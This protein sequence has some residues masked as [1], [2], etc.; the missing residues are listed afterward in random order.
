MSTT[1]GPKPA[2]VLVGVTQRGQQHITG[3]MYIDSGI[4]PGPPREHIRFAHRFLKDVL[5]YDN[6]VRFRC[7]QFFYDY[8]RTQYFFHLERIE[9]KH[10]LPGGEHRFYVVAPV[11][12]TQ[13]TVHAA[14]LDE[15]VLT[16]WKV[17][18]RVKTTGTRVRPR[19]HMT[20]SAATG[21]AWEEE[22]YKYNYV[23]LPVPKNLP[24]S[25]PNK[26]Y[27]ANTCHFD[28]S[29]PIALPPRRT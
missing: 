5:T 20:L 29:E 9:Y 16:L 15:R 27:W 1:T 6:R 3:A 21:L 2:V 14:G 22:H 28:F 18:L 13:V 19:P 17:L 10:V 23:G 12:F 24:D 25:D 26:D 7:D 4:P 8:I 11:V